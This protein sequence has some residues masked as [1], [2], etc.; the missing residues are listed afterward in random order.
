M[1][2]GAGNPHRQNM[3]TATPLVQAD[4]IVR[5]DALRDNRTLLQPTDFVLAG[6]DRVAITGPSGSGKSVLLRALA[7]LDP[8]Q[9]GRVRW[10]GNAVSRT[11]IPRYRRAVAYIRQRPALLDGTVEDNLRYP[12]SLHVYRDARFDRATVEALAMRA[13]RG[14]DFLERQ[15]SELSGGEAQIVALLR[16]LQL[17]PEVLLLDEP[18]ASLDPES[19]HATEALLDA[20]FA[21]APAA[22]ASVWV[23]HDMAQAARVGKRQLSLRAGVLSESAAG[24][25][26]ANANAVA[27]GNASASKSSRESTP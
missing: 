24:L 19:T 23:S 16:V 1:H 18:T 17:A 5:R 13:G 8:L 12:F 21:D 2:R 6:G 20:W 27:P 3:M 26:D 25:P 14:A 4:G 7:L 15:A 10:H 22:R 9:G 11:A